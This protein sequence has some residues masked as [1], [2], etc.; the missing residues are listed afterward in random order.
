MFVTAHTVTPSCYYSTYSFNV[1]DESA[2]H[3][4]LIKE[5]PVRDSFMTNP[6]YSIIGIFQQ[7]LM[8]LEG[9]SSIMLR[10]NIISVSLK[11]ENQ[12]SFFLA[13]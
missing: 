7:M 4:Y 6:L 8:T 1:L 12:F 5:T 9:Q 13:C 11:K 10:W 3:N 2:F